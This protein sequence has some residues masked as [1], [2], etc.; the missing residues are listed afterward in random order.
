[1]R[2]KLLKRNLK[3]RSWIKANNN[4]KKRGKSFEEFVVKCL[5]GTKFRHV[6][7]LSHEHPR[8]YHAIFMLAAKINQT[9]IVNYK[10]WHLHEKSN[11]ITR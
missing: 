6:N 3:R 7:L 10:F 9:K 2:L 8:S 4:C 5:Q 1:M 11:E